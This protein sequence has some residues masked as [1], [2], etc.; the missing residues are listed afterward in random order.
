MSIAVSA[1]VHPSRVLR[2]AV[3]SLCAGI[4]AIGCLIGLGWA[5]NFTFPARIVIVG[6]SVLS[7]SLAS[8]H[9]HRQQKTV[10]I[11]ISSIGNIRLHQLDAIQNRV[12]EEDSVFRL[13]PGSTLWANLMLLNL[14]SENGQI[15]TLPILPDSVSTQEFRALSV[16]LRWIAARS[17]EA[18]DETSPT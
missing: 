10:H 11:D 1:S 7:A 9:F 12:G 18:G 8:F 4:V 14:R 16:A 2:F 5:E 13:M 6:L 15:M 17:G 3:H